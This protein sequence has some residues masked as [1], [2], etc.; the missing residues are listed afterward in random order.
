M[1]ATEFLA[2]TVVDP[3]VTEDSLKEALV[4]RL[5]ATHVEV[6]DISEEI[7]DRGARVIGGCGQSFKALIV[8]PQF[9]GLNSLKRHRLVQAALKEEIAKIHAWTARCQT[10]E[11]WEKTNGTNGTA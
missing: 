6:T 9:V 1:Q 10:A 8:S 5:G 11:E 3:T 7:A 4:E 2:N